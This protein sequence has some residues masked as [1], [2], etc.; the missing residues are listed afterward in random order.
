MWGAS[1]HYDL[2]DIF[3]SGIGSLLAVLTFELIVLW[4]KNKSKNNPDENP[5]Y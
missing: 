4:R 1:T 2:F 3:A 5:G